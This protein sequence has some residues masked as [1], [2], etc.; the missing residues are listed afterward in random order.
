MLTD[1]TFKTLTLSLATYVMFFSYT[2]TRNPVLECFLTV[3][4]MVNLSV[5]TYATSQNDFKDAYFHQPV[6]DDAHMND[7]DESVDESVD[8]SEDSCDSEC[9]CEKE[10][11]EAP[12]EAA[13][14][15]QEELAKVHFD[16]TVDNE[17]TPFSVR[18]LVRA[19][20]NKSPTNAAD[21]SGGL[22]P[23]SHDLSGATPT[24]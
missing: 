6:Y 21:I 4:L 16:M 18:A 2:L 7:D 11:A 13:T 12:T 14:L 5:L 17:P 24:N 3:L 1:T 9:E 22:P 23:C 15:S 19:F 10:E 8:E 20:S